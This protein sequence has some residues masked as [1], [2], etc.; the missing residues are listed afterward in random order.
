[1]YCIGD[2]SAA[3]FHVA[4]FHLKKHLFYCSDCPV[5]NYVYLDVMRHRRK[6]C[7]N[8]KI[9]SIKRQMEDRIGNH[10]YFC[11]YCML[12]VHTKV[13]AVEQ[14]RRKLKANFE[15]RLDFGG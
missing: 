10:K 11:M 3:E 4:K 8:A 15:G 1:M 6:V 2:I 9:Y 12:T 14:N 7:T 13:C 5:Q